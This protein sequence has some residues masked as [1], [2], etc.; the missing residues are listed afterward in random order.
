MLYISLSQKALVEWKSKR[1]RG[2]NPYIVIFCDRL[3]CG[4]LLLNRTPAVAVELVV[5]LAF[6]FTTKISGPKSPV[7]NLRSR[8]AFSTLDRTV[9]TVASSGQTV[10][11][12]SSAVPTLG[13]LFELLSK[14]N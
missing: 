14:P 12:P 10:A 1:I 6:R 4:G 7:Q 9:T 2:T 3:L 8:I 11:R 13:R 5:E